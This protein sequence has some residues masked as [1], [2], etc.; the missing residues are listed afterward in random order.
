[1]VFTFLAYYCLGTLLFPMGDLSYL[2]EMPDMYHNC[3]QEDP[4]VTLT[5]FVFEHLTN[6]KNTESDDEGEHEKPHQA[7][8]HHIPAP[9][10]AVPSG[11][12]KLTTGPVAIMF[13]TKEYPKMRSQDA[14][15]CNP[16]KVFR[17]PIA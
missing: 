8:Y 11:I 13:V 10:A 6:I 2:K 7:I 15:N 3:V 1:M 4:D 16:L 14:L 5:D 17:P 9:V 12:I